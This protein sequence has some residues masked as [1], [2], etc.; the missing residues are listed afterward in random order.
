MNVLQIT[1]SL[2]EEQESLGKYANLS[3]SSH[4][5]DSLSQDEKRLLTTLFYTVIE[6]KITYDYYICAISGRSINDISPRAKNILRLGICQILSINSVPDYAA[7]NESVKLAKS[8]GER[9]FIN[10]V[11]RELVR[12]KDSL[13]LPKRERNIARYLSVKY[14]FPI[15]LVKH[16]LSMLTEEETV[17]LFEHFNGVRYTDISVNL[18]KISRE[19]YLEILNQNGARAK[20]SQYSSL[21]IRING[22][23][24]PCKLFGYNEGYFFV[25]DEASAILCDVL[26]PRKNDLIVDVCSAPGGK[27]FASAS[28]IYGEGEIYS[29]DLKE[30]KL[31]LIENGA[32]RLGFECIKADCLDALTPR[33]ELFF[34]ADGVICDCPCSGLGILGKKADM[35]YKD[36]SAAS[37]LPDL[38]LAILT[39]SKNYLKQGGTLIYSTCTLNEKE[40][41]EVVMRFLAQN[42]D[43]QLT[44]FQC[45]G[46]K[47]DGG[48]LTLL[49]H[50]HN[51][52]GFFIAKLQRR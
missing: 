50:I 36:L 13:P 30:S 23:V 51:T 2:L 18:A 5:T 31:S 35:R 49:P 32:K 20:K 12:Q 16:F 47:C 28:K 26:S 43:F 17:S 33:E 25:Q 15:P 48:M 41:S 39:S 29:F 8:Q 27:S 40:N 21:G 52:D 45:G 11:L 6:R 22:S 19:E 4:K 38:Q 10:G 37:E 42:P 46:I 3:L 44:P 14:S 1:L 34:K 24:N 9:A 7:V